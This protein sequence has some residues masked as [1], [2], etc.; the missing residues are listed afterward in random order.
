VEFFEP[1][2]RNRGGTRRWTTNRWTVAGTTKIATPSARIQAV[3]KPLPTLTKQKK[4]KI[5]RIPKPFRFA[6][7]TAIP[8]CLALLVFASGRCPALLL[9]TVVLFVLFV[10][11]CGDFSPGPNLMAFR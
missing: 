5:P 6:P 7:T 8:K 1:E 10:L 2:I 9:N 3:Y 11:F 4:R